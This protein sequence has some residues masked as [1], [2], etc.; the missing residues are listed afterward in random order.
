M[1]FENNL[2]PV[3]SVI[4]RWEMVANFDTSRSVPTLPILIPNMVYQVSVKAT[5]R[6]ANSL[7]LRILFYNYA[8]EIVDIKIIKSLDGKFI[9]PVEADF[10]A[11]EL[12]SA[13][14]KSMYFHRLDIVPLT[15]DTENLS[16]EQVEALYIQQEKRTDSRNRIMNEV[17]KRGK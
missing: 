14:L 15:I 9:Y 4:Y 6:E 12:V 13:G 10:Y 1:Y 3:G 16:Q 17:I 11:I 8:E 2:L 7:Y 5:L